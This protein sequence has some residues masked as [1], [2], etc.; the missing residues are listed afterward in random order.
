M[1]PDNP[2][3]SC[4]GE[5]DSYWA[6]SFEQEKGLYVAIVTD[7]RD[8][9]PL[10]RPHVAIGTRI[11][12]PNNKIKFNEGNPT[13]HGVLFMSHQPYF[14]VYCYVPPGGV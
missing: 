13:G 10:K 5:A 11:V 4:C 7:E 12:I 6:D 14:F 2:K 8:D 3:M 1:Q 9:A